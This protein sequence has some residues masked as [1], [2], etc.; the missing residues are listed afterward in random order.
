M[1]V[2]HVIRKRMGYPNSA[3]VTLYMKCVLLIY[4][5]SNCPICN[6]SILDIC[7]LLSCVLYRVK[8]EATSYVHGF[9]NS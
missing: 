8:G 7:M 9:V 1:K 3:E 2:K 5:L 4:V 6:G